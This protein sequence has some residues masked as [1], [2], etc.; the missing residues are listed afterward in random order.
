[1]IEYD[2]CPA[3][4]NKAAFKKVISF[5][6]DTRVAAKHGGDVEVIKGIPNKVVAEVLKIVINAI[7]G[8]LGKLFSLLSIKSSNCWKL[9]KI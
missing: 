3:H 8:K 5:I 1:M 2:I 6:K 4:L 7:Y 9:V